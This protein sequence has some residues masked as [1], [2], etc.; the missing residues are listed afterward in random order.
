MIDE[1]QDFSPLELQL[2]INLSP[3]NK[4]SITLAGDMDQKLF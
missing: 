4:K 1:A 3:N 2:L